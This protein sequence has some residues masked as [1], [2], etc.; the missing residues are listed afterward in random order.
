MNKEPYCIVCKNRIINE[1]KREDWLDVLRIQAD[2][3]GFESLT[4]Y[5]QL[6]IDG[7]FCSKDCFEK[8]SITGGKQWKVMGYMP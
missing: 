6:A 7:R 4:E 3:F 1:R 8:L 2:A 5:E